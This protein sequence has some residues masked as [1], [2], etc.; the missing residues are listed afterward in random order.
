M[1]D[2]AGR[3]GD[4]HAL[5]EQWCAV[6]QCSRWVRGRRDQVS[7]HIEG[8]G[9]TV[10]AH[11]RKMGLEGIVSKRRAR[12]WNPPQVACGLQAVHARTI[13]VSIGCWRGRPFLPLNEKQIQA[14]S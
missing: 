3:A 12:G 2:P 6:P 5:V 8:D 14:I 10:F 7:E 13:L 4:Q 9:P 1:T 11:A